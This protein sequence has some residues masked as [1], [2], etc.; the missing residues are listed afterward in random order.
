MGRE[1]GWDAR[2]TADEI[3]RMDDFV[4]RELAA[5]AASGTATVITRPAV[6]GAENSS[7]G[8]RDES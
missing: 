5:V 6:A 1:L 7:T 8:E 3:A 4:A 2:R